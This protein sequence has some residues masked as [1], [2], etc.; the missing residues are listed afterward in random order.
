MYPAMTTRPARRPM[1][2]RIATTRFMRPPTRRGTGPAL[3]R[4]NLVA[5]LVTRKRLVPLER[6]KLDALQ[7]RLHRERGDNPEQ[8]EEARPE[9]PSPNFEDVPRRSVIDREEE[10]PK[11]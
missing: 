11:G 2:P 4:T 9:P 5:R 7:E 1:Q 8:E 10:S 3:D 6:P